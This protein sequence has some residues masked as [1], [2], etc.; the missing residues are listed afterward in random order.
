MTTTLAF[1]EP[2]DLR[3]ELPR[4]RLD[5]RGFRAHALHSQARIGRPVR[6]GALIADLMDRNFDQ[7]AAGGLR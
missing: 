6:L 5:L 2:S 4:P 7:L 3:C 1:E